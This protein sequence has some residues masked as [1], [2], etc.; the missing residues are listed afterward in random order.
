MDSYVMVGLKLLGSLAM[1]MY[2]MK[3]MSEALQKMAGPQL[4]RVLGTMT[5]NRFTSVLAGTFVTATVQSSTAT[6]VMTVSFVSAGLLTL[7]QAISVIMGANIGTTLTAWI[8]TAGFKFNIADFVWPA[9]I[10]SIILIYTKKHTNKGDFLFGLA[11]MFL[12]LGTLRAT[13]ENMHLGEQEAVLNF[14]A[15]FAFNSASLL[16]FSCSV[17]NFFASSS[18]FFCSCRALMI[19]TKV[20]LLI[21]NSFMLTC[22]F[23][24]N[25]DVIVKENH[26]C[27]FK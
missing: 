6:T 20:S 13:G 2:G 15:S 11:F 3:V 21:V 19:F 22:V 16:A 25:H 10:I 23:T 18:R 12:G 9:F 4:R 26:D 17:T 14:F 7:A 5:T 27:L 1:L 8:M 24:L